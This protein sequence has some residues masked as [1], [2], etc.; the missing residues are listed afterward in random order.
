MFIVGQNNHKVF[1]YSLTTGFDIST[2]AYTGKSF[3]VSEDSNPE[4]IEFYPDGTQMFI[5]GEANNNIFQ[6]SLTTAW[7]IKQLLIQAEIVLA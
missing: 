7:D 5:V 1:Q 4:G 3:S 6:Y 2:A